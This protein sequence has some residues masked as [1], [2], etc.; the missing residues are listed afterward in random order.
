[1]ASG[2]VKKWLADKGF[3]FVRNDAGGP[4]V[5]LHASELKKSKF[6]GEPGQGQKLEFEVYQG[7][8]GPRAKNITIAA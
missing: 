6:F 7:E 2:T 1:M 8:Q 4:D 3:G 5:F